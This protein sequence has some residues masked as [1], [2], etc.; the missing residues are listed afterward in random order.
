V[1]S[2]NKT[3]VETTQTGEADN[4]AKLVMG[5]VKVVATQNPNLEQTRVL[6]AM[7]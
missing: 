5:E 3:L 6:L 1:T 4:L 2:I 7:K